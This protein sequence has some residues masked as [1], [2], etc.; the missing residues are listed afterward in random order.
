[1][2]PTFYII[3]D[4]LGIRRM[5]ENIIEEYCLG[6]VIGSASD[7]NS[8]V[9][10]IMNL[11]PEIVLIDLLLPSIDG[12]EILRQIKS[13][14]K[15][16][17]FIMIS[18]VRSKEMIE[19]AYK[20]GI[21]FFINKPLNVVEVVTVIEK[22]SDSFNLRRALQLIE[23]TFER[24]NR[25]SINN[26]EQTIKSQII[27]L[28]SELG[29]VG[30]TG[31]RDLINII[32]MIIYIRKQSGEKVYQYN[33]G[34]IYKRLNIKYID[35]GYDSAISIKAIEQR[36]RR[37]V[38]SAFQ[39]IASIGLDD[40]TNYKFEKYSNNIFDFKEIRKEMSYIDKK[41]KTRGRINIKKFIE[42]IIGF[43]E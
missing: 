38:Q 9:N 30:E 3:D 22:V 18:E 32:E 10:E 21:E 1:M 36:I 5:L 33:I 20:S 28:F 4:D 2:K 13:I 41:S 11:N 7:G 24:K 26:N 23:K 42:G 15:D 8:A 43:I 29:I 25:V 31:S 17:Q 37:A 35:E 27:S 14:K 19:E 6:D 34:D 40:Y 39:N 12:I 16:I